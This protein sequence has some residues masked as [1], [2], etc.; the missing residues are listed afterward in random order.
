MTIAYDPRPSA[1]PNPGGRYDTPG[2][3]DITDEAVFEEAPDDEPENRFQSDD[4]WIRMY[5]GS[6]MEENY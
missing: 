3:R 2:L 4:D 1:L 6:R 5:D